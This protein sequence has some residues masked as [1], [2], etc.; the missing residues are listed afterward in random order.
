MQVSVFCLKMPTRDPKMG[1]LG[2]TPNMG[3][4]INVNPKGISL[5][6]NT[7]YDI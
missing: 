1:R 3:S 7:P 6:G 4:S 5:Y 2:N